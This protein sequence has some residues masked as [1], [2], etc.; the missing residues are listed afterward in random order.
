[1]SKLPN[2]GG[3]GILLP[4]LVS[5][6]VVVGLGTAG[7]FAYI[8]INASRYQPEEAASVGTGQ[9]EV[10]KAI[11]NRSIVENSKKVDETEPQGGAASS[12]ANVDDNKTPENQSGQQSEAS[13]KEGGK[14]QSDSVNQ[15]EATDSKQSDG[16]KNQGSQSAKPV[17]N[18]TTGSAKVDINPGDAKTQVDQNKPTGSG[19]TGKQNSGGNGGDGFDTE[20]F[21]RPNWPKGKFLAATTSDK[22]HNKNCSNGAARIRPENE[23]WFDS[24]EAAKADGYER[25]GICWR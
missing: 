24:E 25:C 9:E 5:V 15:P 16:G 20:R 17:Q 1:M 12:A 10:H 11:S 13:D 2:E 23:L 14:G 7:I 8:G 22:Y 4:F 19:T 3:G 21:D 6:L 18:D